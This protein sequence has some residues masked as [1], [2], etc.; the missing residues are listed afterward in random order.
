MKQPTPKID[1]RS[2]YLNAPGKAREGFGGI[3]AVPQQMQP[4]TRT[5][6]AECPGRTDSHAGYLGGYTPEMYIQMIYSP[7][8][9]A[10]H[11]SPGFRT[12]DIAKQ[13]HCT[14]VCAV[15]ANW[16]VDKMLNPRNSAAIA[17]MIV[18]DTYGPDLKADFFA[19][20]AEFVEHHKKGQ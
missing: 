3:K 4:A 12:G 14:G 17:A 18:R 20:P 15:R 9:V 6:C 10:C 13:R 8:S 5:A 2:G 19:T 16:D 11:S 7:A 1:T